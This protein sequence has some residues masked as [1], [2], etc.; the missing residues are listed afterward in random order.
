MFS[1]GVRVSF[2]E[3]LQATVRVAVREEVTNAVR[4]ALKAVKPETTGEYL[5]VAEAAR[6][7]GVSTKT[8][9]AWLRDGRLTPHHAGRGFRVIRE[10]LIR[11]LAAP[12][13]QVTDVSADARAAAILRKIRGG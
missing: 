12:P 8:V 2:E 10:D 11:F 7:A 4:E 1:G 9:R 5:S 6:V 3:M 13:S